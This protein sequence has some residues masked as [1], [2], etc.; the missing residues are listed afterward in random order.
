VHARFEDRA[1]SSNQGV[2]SCF[3]GMILK[4]KSILELTLCDTKFGNEELDCNRT[5]L[6]GFTCVKKD[7]VKWKSIQKSSMIIESGRS[8]NTLVGLRAQ[9]RAST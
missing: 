2:S 1:R 9:F 4:S 3:V 6:K 7:L 5:S 8:Y